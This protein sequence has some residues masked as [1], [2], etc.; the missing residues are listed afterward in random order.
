[1]KIRALVVMPPERQSL[2]VEAL[3]SSGVETRLA[4][5]CREARQIL[6]AGPGL[7]VVLTD[8]SLADGNWWTVFRDLVRAEQTAKLIV[9]LPRAVEQIPVVRGLAFEVIMPPYRAAQI[10]RTVFA[11][12]ACERTMAAAAA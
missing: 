8:L 7:D 2:F 1:M 9:C 11:A 6:G 3:E 12:T 10:R 4:V 5:N